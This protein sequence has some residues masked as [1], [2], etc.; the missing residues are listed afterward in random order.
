MLTTKEN[1]MDYY[2][3]VFRARS[4]TINF[5]NLLSSY[6]VQCQI[7]NTPRKVNV[8]CGISV[9]FT[10]KDLVIV[11]KLLS[12]RNFDTFGGIYHIIGIGGTQRAI[13]L[14]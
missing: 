3:V 4:Q 14:K 9:K 6:K 10:P 11:E 5:A 13:R 12:R 1:I 2:I 8:S 7:I